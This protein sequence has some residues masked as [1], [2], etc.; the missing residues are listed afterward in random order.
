M[1]IFLIVVLIGVIL[2]LI[3]QG[4]L[5]HFI[6]K[7]EMHA[8][9]IV[10]DYKAFEI[11]K[12]EPALFSYVVMKSDRYKDVSNKGFRLLAGYIFGGNEK[13]QKISMTSPVTMSMDDSVT[14]KFKIP[15]GMSLENMPN[16]NNP[17]VRFASEPEKMMAA[18]RFGG[19]TTDER[20]E[21]YT[22]KLR[23]LLDQNEIKHTDNFSYLGY[24]PPFEVINRRNEIVVEVVL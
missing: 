16:P 4:F 18:I 9:T 14:M 13:N 15:D 11:R 17:D 7:T 5:M 21:E 6:G 23:A 19:W 3:A 22:E 10:K 8:Y 2:V 1:K 12:Y 24:N 20:I